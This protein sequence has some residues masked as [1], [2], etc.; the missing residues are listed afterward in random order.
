MNSLKTYYEAALKEFGL[1]KSL[2][3]N[4]EWTKNTYDNGLNIRL[5]IYK[6]D[7]ITINK[8][9]KIEEPMRIICDY[10]WDFEKEFEESKLGKRIIDKHVTDLNIK[11]SELE[12]T[13]VTCAN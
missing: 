8:M 3:T 2:V 13:I 5:N 4:F 7:N 11:V 6:H 1:P 12:K 9:T 10:F